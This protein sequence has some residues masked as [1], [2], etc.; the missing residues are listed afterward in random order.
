MNYVKYLTD[1]RLINILYPVGESFP[2]KPSKVYMYD[3]NLMHPIHPAEVNAGAVYESFFYSQLLKDN[4]P[5]GGSKNAHFP[6]NTMY[7][8]RVEESMRVKNN[9]NMYYTIGKTEIGEGN[10]I[11]L[12]LFGFLY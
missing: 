4:R 8:F 2:E 11:P 6:V 9:P 5:N 12:W 10:M 1:V 7:D 3:P